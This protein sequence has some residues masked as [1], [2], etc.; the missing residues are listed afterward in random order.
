M[1]D[2]VPFWD[3]ILFIRNEDSLHSLNY[4][5]EMKTVLKAFIPILIQPIFRA[6]CKIRFHLEPFQRTR[7]LICIKC[8]HFICLKKVITAPCIDKNKLEKFDLLNNT[9]GLWWFCIAL[10][11]PDLNNK[12]PLRYT[13]SSFFIP[14]LLSYCLKLCVYV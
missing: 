2:H 14:V 7:S 12:S 5:Q 11:T 13:C 4:Y 9:R 1:P 6:K 8:Q 10:L 3:R